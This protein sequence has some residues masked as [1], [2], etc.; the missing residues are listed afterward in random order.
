[1]ATLSKQGN[2]ITRYLSTKYRGLVSVRD[3][4]VILRKTPFSGGWKIVARKK[5]SVSDKEWLDLNIE[6]NNKL[7]AWKKVTRIPSVRQL[8]RWSFDGVA[9]S[10]LGNTVEPD[11]RDQYG[12]PSW[13]LVFGLL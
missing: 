2:E 3:N 9:E 4:G 6:L 1:M 5:K 13:L 11:G 10:T 7:P 8:E 12:A